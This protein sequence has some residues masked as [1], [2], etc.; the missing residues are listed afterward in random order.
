LNEELP[1]WLRFSGE[2]RARFENQEHIR[3]RPANS[4]FYM[5]SRLRLGLELRPRPWLKFFGQGQDARVVL[6]RRVASSPPLQDSWDLRQAYVQLGDLEKFPFELRVGRQELIYSEER[7]IGASNWSNVGRTFNAVKLRLS[8]RRL[9]GLKLDTFASSVVAA[10]E[11]AWDTSNPGDNLHGMYGVFEKVVP[12]G[13]VEPY[14]Y[15]RLI[16]V[17]TAETGVRGRQDFGTL[18]I[19]FTKR[20]AKKWY[21][22]SDTLWQHGNRGSDQER[23]WAGYWRV[24][25]KLTERGWKPSL[26]AD[27]NYATGDSNPKDGRYTRFEVLYPTPHDKY[28]LA[29]QIGWRN[30]RHVAGILEMNPHKSLV[31]QVKYHSWWL[32][33]ATDGAY[34]TNGSLL[35]LDSTGR[36]GTHIGEELDLQMV[37]T[38]SKTL[39]IGGGMGHIFNGDF[40]NRMTP[41]KSYTFYYL[42]FTRQL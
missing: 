34:A 16:P 2:Y 27:G 21:A 42:S 41:G 15:W 4:D 39:Q 32:A 28:G 18:G 22:S 40:L 8:L 35:F 33:T 5:L 36:S 9:G 14:Y 10:K 20:F 38:P 31:A 3:W 23:A 37:W 12:N 13:T 6:Q 11:G 25:R 29:D 19:R 17:A 24:Q 26:T 7:M 1:K 30:V